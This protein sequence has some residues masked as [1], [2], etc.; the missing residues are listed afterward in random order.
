MP[1]WNHEQIP[2]VAVNQAS[3]LNSSNQVPINPPFHFHQNPFGSNCLMNPHYLLL[4]QG[5]IHHSDAV[6]NHVA[7]YGAHIAPVYRNTVFNYQ[8]F[9]V[10]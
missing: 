5:L 10:D 8:A 4:P 7:Q 1:I 6:N 9:D 2:T 3:F